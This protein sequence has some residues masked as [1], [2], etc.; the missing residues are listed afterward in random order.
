MFRHLIVLRN[1]WVYQLWWVVLEGWPLCL[2]KTVF[3][4]GSAIRSTNSFHRLGR[5]CSWKLWLSPFLLTLWVFFCSPRPYSVILML[6]YSGI[7]GVIMRRKPQFTGLNGKRWALPRIKLAWVF[8]TSKALTRPCYPSN[9]GK[10]FRLLTLFLPEFSSPSISIMGRS[11]LPAWV[12]TCLMPSELYM[13][14]KTFWRWVI[15][16]ELGTI[17]KS[18]FGKT[19]GCLIPFSFQVFLHWVISRQ[20]LWF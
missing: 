4:I 12:V 2:W 19:S 17:I 3:G 6:C 20:M 14:H 8:E 7:G 13:Q 15:S 10:Y 18:V 11:S 5:K 9:F 16:G 1:I